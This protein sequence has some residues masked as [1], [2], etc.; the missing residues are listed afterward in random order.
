MRHVDYIEFW[1]DPNNAGACVYSVDTRHRFNSDAKRQ[2]HT[3]AQY[4]DLKARPG[5]SWTGTTTDT[6]FSDV[7]EMIG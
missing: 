3:H 1:L 2:I 7:V 5:A 4:W 6:H